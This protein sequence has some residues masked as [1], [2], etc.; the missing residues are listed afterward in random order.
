MP[1]GTREPCV[2]RRRMGALQAARG[3]SRS[4]AAPSSCP[5]ALSVHLGP[6][7]NPGT[8]VCTTGLNL[9]LVVMRSRMSRKAS[10]GRGEIS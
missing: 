2:T 10:S 5:S 3:T 6:G 7:M 1:G 4:R 9:M 8:P